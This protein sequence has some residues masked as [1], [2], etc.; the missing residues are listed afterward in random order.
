MTLLRNQVVKAECPGCHKSLKIPANWISEPMKCKHCGLVFQAKAPQASAAKHSS[1]PAPLLSKPFAPP[2]GVAM[3][4]PAGPPAI[5]TARPA[6]PITAGIP[7]AAPVGVPVGG[8][9]AGVPTAAAVPVGLPGS[10]KSYPG[11]PRRSR[12]AMQKLVFLLVFLVGLGS[13][14]LVMYY[15][16]PGLNGEVT[17]AVANVDTE[18]DTGA[19]KTEPSSPETMPPTIAPPTSQKS[20]TR[21][22][23]TQGIFDQTRRTLPEPSTRPRVITRP[24][25][26]P[27]PKEPIK[28]TRPI[29]KP[30]EEMKKPAEPDPDTPKPP[31]PVETVGVPK[32]SYPRRLLAISVNNYPYANPVSYGA[33]DRA[34]E[35]VIRQFAELMK[36]PD[37]QVMLLSD[38]GQIPLSAA[39]VPPAKEVIE[40]VMTD[41]LAKSRAQDH[42]MLLF[43]GHCIEIEDTPYLVPLEGEKDNKDSLIPLDSVYA[44]LAAC[45]AQQKVLILDVCRYDPGR[46]EERGTVAAMG[47]KTDA[48]LAKPPKGVQVLTA[49]VA[50]QKSLEMSD[51][52]TSSGLIDG[53]ILLNQIPIIR[54]AGGL[55]GVTQKPDDPF[56]LDELMIKFKSGTSAMAKAFLRQEQTPRLSGEPT[57]T[58]PFDAKLALP[59]TV[60]AKMPERFAKGVVNG[61][62]LQKLFEF[63]NKIPAVKESD[64]GKPFRVES[65]P[66]Y[67]KDSIKEYTDDGMDTPLRAALD[68]GVKALI[69]SDQSRDLRISETFDKPAN[70]MAL[71]AVKK[72]IEAIQ[73]EKVGE[74]L[75][76]LGKVIDELEARKDSVEKDTKLWQARYDYILARLY[77]RQA[78]VLEYTAM[79]GKIRRDDLPQLDPKINKGWRLSAKKDMSDKDGKDLA[80]KSRKLLDELAKKHKGTPWELI[81]KRE[82]ITAL[83]MEWQPN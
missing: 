28:E 35:N 60:V 32:G 40:Q 18:K 57:K 74:E 39:K 11:A 81:A 77:Q 63:T 8:I 7:T 62:D 19:T 4:I 44:K 50:G 30:K 66:P 70:D 33:N 55:R 53:G 58:L 76:R 43:V 56:P 9:V 48:M 78:Y 47:E 75:F 54:A 22:K 42:I 41:F 69:A 6:S 36:V 64:K 1:R 12:G 16:V 68:E 25:E 17:G 65:L 26:P 82:A 23:P 83:G 38:R 20:V 71:N 67:P 15:M 31:P 72:Q 49:C 73:K 79:L 13:I 27:K 10:P 34:M 29:F 45:P 46:G 3:G 21:S 37:D 80:D 61:A 59:P 24:E 51:R 52:L 2:P 14:G 5:P